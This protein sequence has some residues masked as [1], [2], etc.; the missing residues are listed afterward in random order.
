M[1]YAEIKKRLENLTS[2][3]VDEMIHNLEYNIKIMT[4]VSQEKSSAEFFKKRE[5]YEKVRV[6]KLK[7]A[8][9][10]HEEKKKAEAEGKTKGTTKTIEQ[11]KKAITEPV[12]QEINMK[13]T[14]MPITKAVEI[15]GKYTLDQLQD[16]WPIEIEGEEYGLN[17]RGDLVNGDGE[18]IGQWDGKKIIRNKRPAD[19]TLVQPGSH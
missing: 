14:T 11:A 18:Y 13:G 1:T 5:E 10:K 2:E 7:E 16:F 8:R 19:W 17:V 12:V 4:K 15:V 3:M 6:E 9:R